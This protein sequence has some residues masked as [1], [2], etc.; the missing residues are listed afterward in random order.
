VA[1]KWLKDSE[2]KGN[3]HRNQQIIKR[4]QA[5]SLLLGAV[6]FLSPPAALAGPAPEYDPTAVA[7]L[8]KI[9]KN[10]SHRFPYVWP[11]NDYGRWAGLSW[12]ATEPRQLKG[13]VLPIEG[14]LGER[15]G[16]L[17]TGK[18]DFGGLSTLENLSIECGE[19][20]TGIRVHDFPALK[21]LNLGR[22]H[23]NTLRLSYFRRDSMMRLQDLKTMPN[24]RELDL[25]HGNYE[26]KDFK[27]LSDLKNLETLRL[28]DT[29]FDDPNLLASLPNL[30][31][32]ELRA[33]R[34]MTDGEL[35][36]RVIG[37]LA[38]G[39]DIVEIGEKLPHLTIKGFDDL[40]LTSL[41]LGSNKIDRI[42]GLEK[43]T[44]LRRLNLSGNR[45]REIEGL[46]NLTNMENLDLRGNQIVEIRGLDN[47]LN[48]K[49]LN[50]KR[51]LIAELRGLDNLSSLK[52]LHIDPVNK[53]GG[54][55]H[56]GNL[57][58]LYMDH[59]QDS[60]VKLNA[61]D[62]LN[63]LTQL[64]V[65]NLSNNNITK[66]ENLERLE[67]LNHLDLSENEI[68]EIALTKPL[69]NLESL[70][71]TS[72]RLS[73][74]SKLNFFKNLTSLTLKRNRLDNLEGLSHLDKLTDLDVSGNSL[75]SL[76]PL[77]SLKNLTWLNLSGNELSDFGA[78]KYLEG[79]TYLNLSNANRS[80]SL[81]LSGLEQLT[82]LTELFLS[83]NKLTS[84]DSLTARLER[85]ESLSLNY[86]KINDFTILAKTAPNLRRLWVG[87]TAL[88]DLS[89]LKPLKHLRQLDASRCRIAGRVDFSG[90]PALKEINLKDNRITALTNLE[91]LPRDAVI[92]IARNSLP[93]SQL[94]ALLAD[95]KTS[96]RHWKLGVD[97]QRQ[98]FESTILNVG[99]VYDLSAEKT[100]EG[101]QT[102]FKVYE[103]F[104]S[105]GKAVYSGQRIWKDRSSSKSHTG[106]LTN[107]YKQKNGRFIFTKPGQY[108]IT[109]SNEAITYAFDN[110]LRTYDIKLTAET[111]TITVR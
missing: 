46:D 4:S 79:L 50:L 2:Y 8:E 90:W 5:L 61:I 18:L 55:E 92:D 17:F 101:R 65:L 107:N 108:F 27:H 72:N 88:S 19:S 95:S 45:I 110:Q 22:D 103:L 39:G 47:L 9:K 44:T 34:F 48:L 85:L 63:N 37:A 56:L 102:I 68:S 82:N 105:S 94:H 54:L 58:E 111:S 15:Q 70:I 73:D 26:K 28:N 62:G 64:R 21:N 16:G 53:I 38:E 57:E 91:S 78:L 14:L 109:M 30:K 6:F 12:S 13:L 60:H 43:L 3:M 32:L 104:E 49:S 106:R 83:H 33:I 86:N 40:R 75:A 100:F 76:E 24:L 98:V 84:L 11:D 51:N 80:G 67:N 36:R 87:N 52:I 71:L 89:Q 42:E 41:D 74:L 20:V 1:A 7:F 25:S 81:D 77:K 31:T 66:L 97:A 10:I 35:V 23:P 99:Q 29:Y 69:N 96:G 59:H 93:L